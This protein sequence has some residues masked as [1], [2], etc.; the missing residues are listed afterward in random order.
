MEANTQEQLESL[1]KAFAN[2]T[3][4]AEEPAAEQ[5][6]E[7][8]Q[9]E[10]PQIETPEEKPEG[11]EP[12]AETPEGEEGA[13]KD[14][15]TLSEDGTAIFDLG[16]EEG[17]GD[18]PAEDVT[19]LKE[20]IKTLLEEKERISATPKLDP[21]LEKMQR[22]LD[23][24][25]D[26]NQSFWELQS[27]NYD[28]SAIKDPQHSLGMLR[29]KLSYIDGLEAD[30]V[31]HYIKKNFP[32]SYSQDED[33]DPDDLKDEQMDLRVKV[34]EALPKLKKLQE[35]VLLPEVDNGK[36]QEEQAKQ[37]NLYRA[38]S[39][40]RL[41]EIESITFDVGAETPLGFPLKGGAKQQVKAIV[42]EPENQQ[43]FF[44]K[45]YEAED[46]KVDYQK[47]ARD[48]FVLNNLDGILKASFKY[49]GSVRAKEMLKELQG[50]NAGAPL[51]APNKQGTARYAGLEK[52]GL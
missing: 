39:N 4:V 41:D 21:R 10:Q 6:A 13:E 3:A 29:D 34:R 47:F 40:S 36:A 24:G 16:T 23:Q 7:D 52:I 35:D 25:K 32:L 27:K 44:Q 37:I 11:T 46:G 9:E 45:R 38:E 26:I 33:A 1:E 20:Q 30:E 22:W 14:P 5:T 19:S 50:E 43:T 48:V 17:E 18:A 31:D 8:A 15:Y 28:V 2:P 12:V 49:G 42:T 51:K